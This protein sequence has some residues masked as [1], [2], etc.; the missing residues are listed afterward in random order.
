MRNIFKRILN[1]LR[2]LFIFLGMALKLGATFGDKMKLAWFAIST[3]IFKS[4][5]KEAEYKKFTIKVLGKTI[6]I[7]ISHR[8]GDLHVIHE[9]FMDQDYHFPEDIKPKAIFDLGSNIGCTAL[10]FSVQYPEATIY[11]FEPDPD[12]FV[13]LKRNIS[14]QPNIKA[15]NVAVAGK[16]GEF[17]FYRSPAFH[18]R[19]SMI[20]RGNDDQKIAVPG[21]TLSKALNLAGVTHVDFM[22]IDIEGGELDVLDAFNNFDSISA[23]SGELHP[24]VWKPGEEER[25]VEKL[26]KFYDLT[27]TNHDKKTFFYAVKK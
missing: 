14:S 1:V 23:M 9:T 26:K 5:N 13:H 20:K 27:V 25:L 4:R 18:M 22:K 3:R 12:T 10:Y 19:S 15:F 24:Y 7:E 2:E 11:C 8:F 17:D 21:V 16:D 6:P